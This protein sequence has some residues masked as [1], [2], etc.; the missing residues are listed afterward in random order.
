MSLGDRTDILDWP[1]ART[2]LNTKNNT[3]EPS[4]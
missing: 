3:G 2:A 4:E 1:F